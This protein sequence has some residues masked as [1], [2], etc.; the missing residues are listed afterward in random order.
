MKTIAKL[1]GGTERTVYRYLDLLRAVGFN[2]EKDINSK[3]YIDNGNLDIKQ[4]FTFE[5]IKLIQEAI[6]V[7]AKNSPLKD[8]IIKKLSF[9]NEAL[10]GNNLL[11][12]HLSNLVEKV[13]KGIQE[14][15]V[16]VLKKYYSANSQQ[17]NDR[18][19]EPIKFTDNYTSL[20]AYEISTSRIK[21]FKLERITDV[22]VKK[23]SMTNQSKHED[24]KPDVFG[25][26]EKEKSYDLIMKMSLRAWLF[27]KD[28]YPMT[29]PYT[30]KDKK[31]GYYILKTTVYSLAPAKR[32]AKGL[33]DE[34]EFL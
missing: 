30:K 14:R 32:F 8:S 28:E 22:Q 4:M 29:I 17:I 6:L 2:V 19:V 18:Q 16:I 10:A 27:L 34:I 31:S 24:V 13:T 26:G 12:V 9:N 21:Y 23:Q 15:K 5:E 11:K 20:I 25:F 7:V 3:I 1:I 33:P